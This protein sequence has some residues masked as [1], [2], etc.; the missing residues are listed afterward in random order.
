VLGRVGRCKRLGV[1][2]TYGLVTGFGRSEILVS[3]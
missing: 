3:L 1:P 2:I